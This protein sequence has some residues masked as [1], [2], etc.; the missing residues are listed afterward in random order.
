MK[1]RLEAPDWEE[2]IRIGEPW[3]DPKFPK[4][5][6]SLFLNHR[7][8]QDDHK[9]SKAKWVNGFEWK[10]ASEFFGADNFQ[11]FEGIDP[12]DVIMGSCNNCYAFAAISGLAEADEEEME[13]DQKERCL[14]IRDNFLTKEIN[15][16]GCYA[17]EFIIDGEPRV[18][19]V[20]DWFP[21]TRT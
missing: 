1:G 14:R 11:V 13:L 20:D 10:R 17:I 15:S 19:V 2:I 21:F 8:P 4:G 16:A 5:K 6:Y 18:V 9:E 12:D 3:N 7:E